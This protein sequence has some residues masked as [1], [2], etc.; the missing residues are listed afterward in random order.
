MFFLNDL[1]S[2]EHDDRSDQPRRVSFKPSRI[3][4][5]QTRNKNWEHT[6]RAFVEDEDI[7]MGG[8]SNISNMNSVRYVSN[9]RRGGKRGGWQRTGSPAP[10]TGRVRKLF[11]GPTN[12]YKVIVS[13]LFTAQ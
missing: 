3:D 11:E 4:N 12:W 5:V 6:I 1:H 10:A 13:V 8:P 9:N 7:D 2:P